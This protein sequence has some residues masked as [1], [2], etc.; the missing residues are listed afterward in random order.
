M[1]DLREKIKKWKKRD[2]WVTIGF[3]P[4][5]IWGF[6]WALVLMEPHS[7]MLVYDLIEAAA[8]LGVGTLAALGIA[9]WIIRNVILDQLIVNK[10]NLG[11]DPEFNKEFGDWKP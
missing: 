6:V 11:D 3:F 7:S 1:D 4:A 10:L 8:W 5:A 9:K 2:K